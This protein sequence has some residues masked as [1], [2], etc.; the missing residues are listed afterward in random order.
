[1]LYVMWRAMRQCSHYVMVGCL[2]TEGE[3]WLG[4]WDCRDIEFSKQL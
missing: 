1:M 4:C 2:G 3:L